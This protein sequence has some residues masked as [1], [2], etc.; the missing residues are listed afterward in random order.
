MGLTNLRPTTPLLCTDLILSMLCSLVI[1]STI[2]LT[3][4]RHLWLE[5][6]VTAV[7]YSYSFSNTMWPGPRPTYLHAKF[8]LDPSN[9]LAIIHERHRQDRQW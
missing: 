2:L 4:Y 9:R 7:V 8:R 1:L 5:G 6:N 3:A